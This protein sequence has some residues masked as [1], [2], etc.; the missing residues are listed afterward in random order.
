MNEERAIIEKIQK[1]SKIGC[2]VTNVVKIFC[3][4]MSVVTIL[5]GCI[6]VG[7]SKRINVVLGEAIGEDQ[8]F[9]DGMDLL[10]ET[11]YQ[12]LMEKGDFATV[13]GVELLVMGAILICTAIVVHFVRKV[14]REMGE[15]YS[16]FQLSI[17][18]NLKVA[19]VLVTLLTLSSSLAIAL[20]VGLSLWCVIHIFEYGC[21]LQRQSDETL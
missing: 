9:I 10:E 7:E 19:F 17:V 1:T 20:I 18:K 14:F 3:I 15:S 21:E 16:P 13:L 8:H 5:M 2:I 11:L 6:L 12:T 4:V